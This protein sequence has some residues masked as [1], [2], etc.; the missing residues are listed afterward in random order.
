MT[1]NRAQLDQLANDLP[2]LAFDETRD[3]AWA[4]SAA[5]QTYLTAYSLDF[6]RS[7][8]DLRH[9]FGRLDV[10]DFKI[11]THYWLPARPIATLVIV[12]GYYDHVGLFKHAINFALQN[13]F[14]V[15]TF[16]LPGHGLSSGPEAAIDSF[17]QYGDVVHQ[18][19]TRAASL[20][21]QPLHALGQSTGAA[22]LLNYLWRYE[23]KN[24]ASVA[25]KKIVLLAP[26]IIPRGWRS[27]R[28]LYYVARLFSKRFPRG[29]SRS[30]HDLEF[31]RFIE[32]E[33]PLQ[34][35]Y[36][37]LRWVGAMAQWHRFFLR[38]EPMQRPMLVV[39]GTGD[40]TVAWRYNLRQ[41][42]KKLPAAE[43][44]MIDDAGHQLIN[45]SPEYRDKLLEIVRKWFLEK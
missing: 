31:I 11:A 36:L 8:T 10:C 1:L 37:S 29:S 18:V 9:G 4:Q 13:N 27:G 34:S 39:Q 35:R 21:P 5:V 19:L 42:R 41:I 2:M 40:M 16:D 7:F 44:H 14:A 23:E 45:E 28:F 3:L 15:L 25:L 30:S 20:L 6:T 33:D 12:H 26:L 43:I 24:C 32:S 17:D 22:V 38:A